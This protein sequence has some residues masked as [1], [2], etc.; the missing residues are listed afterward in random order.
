MKNYL[1]TVI[2]VYYDELPTV[3]DLLGYICKNKV[4]LHIIK[5][6]MIYTKNNKIEWNKINKLISKYDSLFYEPITSSNKMPEFADIYFTTEYLP[7]HTLKRQ[8]TKYIFIYHS[9]NQLS[10]I[11]KNKNKVVSNN[12]RYFFQFDVIIQ[13]KK[14]QPT[15]RESI[16]KYYPNIFRDRINNFFNT[17]TI[18]PDEN[19]INKILDIDP[20]KTIFNKIYSFGLWVDARI[21][22]KSGVKK[23]LSFSGDGS[24]IGISD[25][26]IETVSSFIKKNNVTQI[27]DLSCGDMKWMSI[28]LKKNK[29]ITDYHGN[30][31]SLT[32]IK[33]AQNNVSHRKG[34]NITFSNCNTSHKSFSKKLS[35]II[36]GKTLIISRLTLQHMTNQE[37]IGTIKNLIKYV[38]FDFIGLSSIKTLFKVNNKWLP[39]K[40]SNSQDINRGGYR[41]INLNEHPFNKAKPMTVVNDQIHLIGKESHKELIDVNYYRYNE[42]IKLKKIKK[43]YIEHTFTSY[44]SKVHK[45]IKKEKCKIYKIK[46]INNLLE[47]NINQEILTNK[48]KWY[49]LLPT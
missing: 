16:L 3:I 13:L 9:I 1:D 39:D 40:S 25:K 17:F 41:G 31:V 36:K 22:H 23:E 33:M 15:L 28:V 32:A 38:K 10:W 34:L 47:K 4:K 48:R 30:D 49:T 26:I 20:N 42:F 45:K 29:Q 35:K 37:I 8:Y 7:G 2:N 44:G 46:H 21:L 5:I 11:D 14:T 27:I 6:N 18:K 24:D 19:S 43:Y 12:V